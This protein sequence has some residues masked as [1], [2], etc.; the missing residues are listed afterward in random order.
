MTRRRMFPGFALFFLLLAPLP[1]CQDDHPTAVEFE[2]RPELTVLPE[3]VCM[4]AG[5]SLQFVAF[6]TDNR[7]LP[8]PAPPGYVTTWESSNPDVAQVTA[9]GKVV[10]L[11]RGQSRVTVAYGRFA[12]TAMIW[13]S[14][15]SAGV[16]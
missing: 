4:A 1:G 6:F 16:K 10:A 15:P 2:F 7:G 12:A 14:D 9:Y 13:V 8:L 5:D 3:V 11:A